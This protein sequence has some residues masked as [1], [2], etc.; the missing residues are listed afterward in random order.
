MRREEA[1][2]PERRYDYTQGVCRRCEVPKTEVRGY[3]HWLML[4]ERCEQ[5]G[6]RVVAE[7]LTGGSRPAPTGSGGNYD[8]C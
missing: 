1:M 4:N 8:K 7:G 5:C 3:G 6:M 2:V